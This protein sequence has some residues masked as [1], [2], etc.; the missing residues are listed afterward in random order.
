M[1]P[2]D[3][4]VNGLNAIRM[5]EGRALRAYQDSVGVWTVGYGLTNMDK[6][7]PWRIKR[8]LVITEAE[9]EWYLYHSL[10][11]NYEPDVRQVL[12]FDKLAHPQGALD[13]GMS[14]HFNTGGIKRATWPKLLNAGNLEGA[15]RSLESWCKAGGRTLADL[16]RR[17]AHEWGIISAENYGHVTGPTVVEPSASGRETYHGHGDLLT[18]L[19]V[20]PGHDPSPAKTDPKEITPPPASPGALKLGDEGQEVTELQHKI[21]AAGGSVEVTGKY[22]EQTEAAVRKFQRA[23]PNLTNDG[24][25][26]PATTAALDRAIQLIEAAKKAGKVAAP[27]VPTA[28]VGFH[29]FVS[30]HAGNIALAVA[31]IAALAFIAY[32]IW[33]Y[34]HD[35]TA[36]ANAAVGRAV[37]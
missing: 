16:V 37:P 11:T 25:A 15:R 9:A 27:T 32:L 26:G 7:L 14:F 1:I 29:Q 20:P 12:H 24:K 18:A 22:D 35:L 17:R 21:N 33:H 28:Y 8:G 2:T 31:G 4:S 3:I 6:G 19:P 30:A 34:R 23:H 5:E 13:G 10:K 36:K